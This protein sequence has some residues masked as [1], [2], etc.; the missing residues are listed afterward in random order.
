MKINAI[1]Y[2]IKNMNFMT[3]GLLSLGEFYRIALLMFEL[4]MHNV[5]TLIVSNSSNWEDH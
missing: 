5:R 2:A 4:I 1:E 3:M